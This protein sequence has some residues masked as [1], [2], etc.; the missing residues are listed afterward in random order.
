MGHFVNEI[1]VRH[2]VPLPIYLQVL[3]PSDLLALADASQRQVSALRENG[4]APM[5]IKWID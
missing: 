1:G 4:N 2:F 3:N 5:I